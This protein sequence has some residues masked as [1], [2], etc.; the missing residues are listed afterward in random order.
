M[1]I[2]D[3]LPRNSPAF[4]GCP[5]PDFLRRF[6][7]M[8]AM[9]RGRKRCRIKAGGRFGARLP[10]NSAPQRGSGNL[11][12]VVGFQPSVLCQVVGHPANPR[13]PQVCAQRRRWSVP[14]SQ[15]K[16]IPLCPL[17]QSAFLLF[18][19]NI[20]S[21]SLASSGL[22]NRIEPLPPRSKPRKLIPPYHSVCR[23]ITAS[24]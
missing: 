7:Q 20:L 24:R 12:E 17:P 21:N 9:Q 10:L 6:H 13:R 11:Q 19:F 3:D 15:D 5:R 4:Q 1:P 14:K 2:P 16:S 23:S 8:R 18:S 22:H